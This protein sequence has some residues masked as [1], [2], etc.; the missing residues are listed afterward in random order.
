MF[1]S[2]Y[3]QSSVEKCETVFKELIKNLP[4]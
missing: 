3:Q 4:L 1:F 2:S